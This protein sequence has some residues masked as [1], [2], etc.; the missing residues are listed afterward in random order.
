MIAEAWDATFAL[1]DGQPTR[2]DLDRLAANVPRQE[3]GR[4]SERELTLSRANRSVRLWSHV[5]DA[6]RAGGQPDRAEIAR[7]GYLM[8]TTAVYGSGKFGLA[9]RDAIADRPEL[10]VPFQAEMLTVWLIRTF[11]RDLAEHLGGGRLDPEIARMLGIGNSTGLGM[12]P[13]LITHPVLINNW[14]QTREKAL[15]S[16]RALALAGDNTQS[17]FR[18]LIVR[19]QRNAQTWHSAHPV[20]TRKTEELRV[21]LARLAALDFDAVFAETQPWDKLWRWGEGA[22]GLEGQ[23][24][25]LSL[26]LEPHGRLIDALADEL[27]ADEEAAFAID[28]RMSAGTVRAM[29]ARH[30]GWAGEIDWQASEAQARLWYV[31]A[32]KLEPRLA[33]RADEMLEPYEQPLAPGR[34]V[35]HLASALSSV[36][37]H[38]PIAELLM[39]APE[40]RQA[41]RRVQITARHPYAEI[42]DNTID[43]AM[44]PIDLLR[45]KLSMFGAT[46]FDP[47]SDRWV[48]I[49]MYQGAPYPDEIAHMPAD[50]WMLPA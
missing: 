44:M 3:A 37:D 10:N 50:D 14:M 23:E 16:V 30:Y 21:D 28:G 43:A 34:D 24:Q 49:T 25:L 19:A 42:R 17:I 7:V 11:V 33:E 15:A 20:Q 38:A 13:F 48:R 22:L 46:R 31:S 32:E 5:I 35:T 2:G 9:D 45:A 4:V 36:P 47:R 26:M 27:A 40:H 8:R 29:I 6:L 39:A 12:A 1:F 18:S 41:V